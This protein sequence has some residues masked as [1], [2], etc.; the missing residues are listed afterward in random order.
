ME[1]KASSKDL[2][3][4]LFDRKGKK[5]A[6][7][8][9]LANE[10]YL[11]NTIFTFQCFANAFAVSSSGRIGGLGIFWNNEMKI[12]I[13]PHSQYHIDSIVSEHGGSPWRLTCVYRKAQT[14]E[15]F[16][17]WD[18][19]KHIRSS[20]A[21]PWVCI[22]DFNEV[23]FRSEYEGVQER[24]FA[25][26]EGFREM[27]D[28]CGLYDLGFEGRKWTYEKRVI[29]GS[30]CRVHLDRALA[31]PDWSTRYPMATVTNMAAATSDHGPILLCWRQRP[32]GSSIPKTKNKFHY[33]IMWESHEEF[34]PWLSEIW[35]GDKAITL[36][37]LRQKL[38]TA[39]KGMT[40]WG[41]NTFGHVRL[42]LKKLKEELEMLQADPHRSGPSHA[43]IKI[44]DRIVEL[45]HREEIMWQQHSRIRWLAAGEKNTRFFHLRASQ[46]KKKTR[47][48]A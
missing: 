33:E 41:R 7:K 5:S 2:S 9:N 3:I 11:Q 28:V 18:M 32:G 24:R 1:R 30:Y 42:E 40:S 15:R 44:F 12:D 20:S 23:L 27:T 37:E 6:R 21:L 26:M 10:V 16:N 34:S 22:G 29:G 8:R 17:T 13:L 39:A 48:R 19:L 47:S 31:T 43:E 38:S 36:E 45:N 46:R 4:S 25:Q 14:N 35:R